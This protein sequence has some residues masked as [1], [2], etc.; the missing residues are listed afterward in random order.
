MPAWLVWLLPVPVMTIAAM[1]WAAWT[2]RSRGPVEAAASVQAHE[3]FR[4]ALAAP[5]PP[6]VE[7]SRRSR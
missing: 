1:A 5:M 2:G 3:R 4:A 6:Q 7:G